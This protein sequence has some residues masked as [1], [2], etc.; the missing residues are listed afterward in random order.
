MPSAHDCTVPVVLRHR[1]EFLAVAAHGKKWVA[2]GVI[3]QMKS[4]SASTDVAPVSADIRFG[5][6]ASKKVGNAVTRNRARR[7]LRALANE[8]LPLHGMAGHDYVL[9]ARNTTATRD[10]QDLRK[11]LIWALKRIA[12]AT[13]KRGTAG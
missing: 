9:I 6:T 7:R 8:I 11:D 4:P 10:F 12:T 1:A 2:T 3:L 13:D 5:L